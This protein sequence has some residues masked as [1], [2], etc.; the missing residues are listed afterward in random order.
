M[1]TEA[2]SE[3][4]WVLPGIIDTENHDTTWVNGTGKLT[5]SCPP[6]RPGSGP[7]AVVWPTPVCMKPAGLPVDCPAGPVGPW[8]PVAP[9]GPCRPPGPCGPG[10]PGISWMLA[11]AL[12][13]ALVMPA[14]SRNCAAVDACKQAPT[15]APMAE[16][17]R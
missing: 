14:Q 11:T 5:V 8:L 13:I 17:D 6:P 3:P 1:P 15:P 12:W 9:A 2:G 16:A 4:T 7:V 10:G